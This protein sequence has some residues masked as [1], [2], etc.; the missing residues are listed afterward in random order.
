MD[1]IYHNIYLLDVNKI[2]HFFFRILVIHVIEIIISA[3]E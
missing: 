1:Q 2:L 3:R